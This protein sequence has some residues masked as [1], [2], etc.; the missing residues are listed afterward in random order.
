MAK[1]VVV[2][3]VPEELRKE[4]Y[5]ILPPT[6]S[7]IL[8]TQAKKAP[9]NGLTGASQLRYIAG[10]IGE[11]Y[12]PNLSSWTVRP[13]L[14]EGRPFKTQEELSA[15][16]VQM[17]QAQYPQ[18]FQ[19]YLDHEIKQRPVGTKLI[20]YVGNFANTAPFFSNGI[21]LIDEK[22]VETYLGLK[23]KKVVGKP[24]VTKEQAENN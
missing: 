24:A 14:F 9:H 4:E 22:D 12:D 23:P 10:A 16:V 8:S 19:T 20:Y 6:F 17:L 3:K 1:F 18:I 2:D 15:I 13:H 11:K 7:D 21:D 5:A